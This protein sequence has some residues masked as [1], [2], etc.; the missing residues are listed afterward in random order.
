MTQVQVLRI[1][2]ESHTSY[3]DVRGCPMA[4]ALRRVLGVEVVYSHGSFI[5]MDTGKTTYVAPKFE[6]EA[7]REAGRLYGQGEEVLFEATILD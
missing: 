1:D 3:I 5:N 7:Y 4:C 2:W 6:C